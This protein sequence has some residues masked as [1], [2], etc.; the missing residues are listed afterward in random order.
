MVNSVSA[1][2][3]A[4]RP[5]G[6]DREDDGDERCDHDAHRRRLPRRPP[7]SRCC[8]HAWAKRADQPFARVSLT[9]MSTWPER[10]RSAL[11]AELVTRGGFGA[12]DIEVSRIEVSVDAA[13]PDV[14]I[15]LDAPRR[16]GVSFRLRFRAPSA[17]LA[18]EQL[19]D[20]A[21][22]LAADTWV[23][24]VEELDFDALDRPAHEGVVWIGEDL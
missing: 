15:F 16:P 10:L 11:H 8:D 4:P 17:G 5:G 13:D 23:S 7:L 22:A 12:H 2:G 20:F 14:C 3:G 6:A 1:S 9:Q 19:D 24:L 18:E 21:R